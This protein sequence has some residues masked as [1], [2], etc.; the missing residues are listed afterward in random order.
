[1][2]EPAIGFNK[3]G[4]EEYKRIS[5]EVSRRVMN[6]RPHRGRWQ[7][8]EGSGGGHT[9][10]FTIDSVLCPGVDYVDEKTLVVTATWYTAGC[11]KTPPGANDDGTYNVYDICNYLSYYTAT[12]LVGKTG[13]ATY[14]Y[15]L[16]GYCEPRWIVE[17]LCGEPQCR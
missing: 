8:R 1:M 14:Y 3:E 15:P 2:T 13:R 9:I 17:D 11:S 10:W 4:Y 5:L 6:E 12:E 16:T 7:Q